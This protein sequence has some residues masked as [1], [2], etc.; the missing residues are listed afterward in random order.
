VIWTNRD[1]QQQCAKDKSLDFCA[2]QNE[3]A[4]K[5]GPDRYWAHPFGTVNEQ[6]IKDEMSKSVIGRVSKDYIAKNIFISALRH[7]KEQ[8]Q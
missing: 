7:P 6:T 2:F 3:N 4:T 5:L 8:P 1:A